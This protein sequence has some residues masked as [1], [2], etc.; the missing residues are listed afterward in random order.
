MQP[1]GT[2]IERRIDTDWFAA[3]VIDAYDDGHGVLLYDLEYDEGNTE[4]EVPSAEI[5]VCVAA[6]P[7]PQCDA[8]KVLVDPAPVAV[9]HSQDDHDD[10]NA[11]V[12]N[13]HATKLGAGSGL[14]GVRFLRE[15]VNMR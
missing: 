10:M 9:L 13:G 2:R 15:T 5:R 1:V 6:S 4:L 7:R 12:V 8:A 11:F 14:H 3:T